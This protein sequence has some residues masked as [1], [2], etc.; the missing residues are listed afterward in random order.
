LTPVARLIMPAIVTYTSA[1]QRQTRLNC[2]TI[3]QTTCGDS[4][5]SLC[6]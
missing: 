3:H 5:G 4:H 1:C 6:E 2:E